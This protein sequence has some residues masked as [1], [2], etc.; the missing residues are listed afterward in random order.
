MTRFKNRLWKKF[1]L[2]EENIVEERYINDADIRELYQFIG[3]LAPERTDIANIDDTRPTYG[4]GTREGFGYVIYNGRQTSLVINISSARRQDPLMTQWNPP[5]LQGL[6]ITVTP[7]KVITSSTITCSKAD[8]LVVVHRI[9]NRGQ[10]SRYQL[11]VG[12]RGAHVLL[13]GSRGFIC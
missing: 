12:Q 10:M 11:A 1:S 6:M 2:H 9:Y 3:I 5:P 7:G 4:H 13:S 8:Y